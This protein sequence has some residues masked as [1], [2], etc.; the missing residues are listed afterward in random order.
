MKILHT[1]DWHIG[2]IVKEMSM[3]G[4]Q[5]YIFNQIIN[6]IDEEKIDAVI[7]AGDI[8]DRSVAPVEAVELLDNILNSIIIEKEIPILAIAGNHDSPERIGFGSNLLRDKGLYI[9]GNLE[10]NI[11]KVELKDKYGN[12][13]FY[14]MP[15]AEPAHVRH[16][17]EDDTIRTHE[18]AMIKVL[19]DI[20]E[21]FKENDRNILITHG[22]ITNYKEENIIE[23]EGG[24]KERGGLI[25]SD[26]ERPLSIGGTDLI[27]ANIFDKFDYVA[28]GHLH[29][30]QKVLGDKIRYSGSP[31]K[32]SFSEVNQKKSVTIIEFEDKNNMNVYL[33]ELKPLRDMRIIKGPLDKLLSKEVYEGTNVE[34]YISAVITDKGE[35]MDIMSKLKAVY[36]R[37][38]EVKREGFIGDE[39][40]KLNKAADYK[41][42]SKLELFTE[43][44]RD[45][46]G[47]ELDE[48]KNQVIE[49]IMEKV[50]GGKM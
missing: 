44:Y 10:K 14:L 11:R 25:V 46:T 20:Y 8:Y 2:K 42:K 21:E 3:L 49:K 7:V 17:Y 36:P 23:E 16:L 41:D 45:I 29:G 18:D 24:I 4:D 13:N 31:L 32:Y 19:E 35:I 26:S 22:Y 40:D 50:E 9:E 12:L 37:V 5:R 47:N 48:D 28:L 38:L 33:R 34:D 43:F 39:I 15:Y 27:S 30:P 1:S 6:I